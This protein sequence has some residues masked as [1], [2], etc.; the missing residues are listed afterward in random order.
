MWRTVIVSIFLAACG[1]EEAPIQG[2]YVPVDCVCPEPEVPVCP[3]PEQVQVSV[4]AESTAAVEGPPEPKKREAPPE[5]PREPPAALDPR[6]DLN[7]ASLAELQTLPRVGPSTAQRIIDYRERRP[8]R[9][10]RDLMRV[11]GIGPK[12]YSRLEDK[13]VV[14]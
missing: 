4:D 5:A 2:S 8:F 1:V 10:A 7:S 14:R 3:P 11:K 12:T 9:R 6:V 13:I